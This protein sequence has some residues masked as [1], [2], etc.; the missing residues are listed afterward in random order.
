MRKE[1]LTVE[2]FA[3]WR[4]NPMTQLVFKYLINERD[5]NYDLLL[6]KKVDNY[7]EVGKNIGRLDLIETLLKIKFDHIRAFI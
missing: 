6:G 5:R 7:L 3:D 2:A 1:D 4:S